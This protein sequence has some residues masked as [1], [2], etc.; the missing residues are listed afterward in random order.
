MYHPMQNQ[1]WKNQSQQ[2]NVQS[3]QPKASIAN[4]NPQNSQAK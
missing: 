3:A 2:S 1:W 4:N